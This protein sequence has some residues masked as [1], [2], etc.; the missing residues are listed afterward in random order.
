MHKNQIGIIFLITLLT[1][2]N[3]L[4]NGFVGDDLELIVNNNFYKSWSNFSRIFT[5][6]Y[7]SNSDSLMA[8]IEQ[9]NASGSVAYRPVLSATYFFDYSLW[10][11]NPFGYHLQNL[12]LHL[13]NSWLVYFLIF[14]IANK[15]SVALLS[16][17]LFSVHPFKTEAVCSIGYRADS[18][19]CLFLLISFICYIQDK[20]G[21]VKKPWGLFLSLVFFFLGLFSKESVII[22]PVLL[23]AYDFFV[24]K[25]SVERLSYRRYLGFAAIAGFYLYF[26]IF[27]FSNSSLEHVGLMGGSLT[28]H[29]VTIFRIFAEYLITFFLPFTTRVL[30]PL[31]KPAIDVL[32]GYQTV[33]S[34]MIFGFYIYFLIKNIKERKIVGF[35]LLWFL[36]AFIPVANIVPIVNPMAYRFMYLPS[37]GLVAVI[38]IMMHQLYSQKIFLT[39]SNLKKI[40][41]TSLI[42]LC[43]VIT[44]PLNTSWK[45]PHMMA[46]RMLKDN[47]TNPMGYFFV[48]VSYNQAGKYKEA[49]AFLAKARELGFHD[50]RIYYHLGLSTLGNPLVAT[51]YFKTGIRFFSKYGPSYI[52]LGRIYFLE[53]KSDLALPLLEKGSEL[54][55]LY[56]A[57][58]YLIQIYLSNKDQEQAQNILK[59]AQRTIKNP[60]QLQSLAKL[61]T[62]NE[63]KKFPI[64]LGI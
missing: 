62:P 19:A 50:P 33:L 59:Q 13:F 27:V 15:Q 24:S 7:I 29:I 30:P 12:L 38:A 14:L 26:Y 42:A 64:D 18:L 10:Q 34:L 48:G 9:D 8:G 56:S 6:S 54:S 47:P 16:A 51:E 41:T 63:D 61:F 25:E 53:G 40:L 36:L 22:Y 23:L 39:Y 28:T 60:N 43:V 44:I 17:L 45:N 55:P 37:I 57:Y 3:A 2:G 52:A 58:G 49:Y 32:W 5:P 20:R 31:Y 4:L 35:F 21:L 1:F 11:L 46:L